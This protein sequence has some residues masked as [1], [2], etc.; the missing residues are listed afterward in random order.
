MPGMATHH[1]EPAQV[2]EGG[3]TAPDGEDKVLYPTLSS[4]HGRDVTDIAHYCREIFYLLLPPTLAITVAIPVI[5]WKCRVSH[6]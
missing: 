1:A 5:V 4:H 6:Y 3:L 2:K